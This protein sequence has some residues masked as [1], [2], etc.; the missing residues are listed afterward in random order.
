MTALRRLR[1]PSRAL[2]GP[3]VLSRPHRL[4]PLLIGTLAGLLVAALCLSVQG[5][6]S[7]DA[8]A[9]RELARLRQQNQTLL[10]DLERSRLE[11]RMASAQARELETQIDAQNRKLREQQD[12]LAFLHKAGQGKH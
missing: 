12:E 3:L 6:R 9:G 10:K 8:Q 1:R 4:R 2:S 11:A 7:P 5:L